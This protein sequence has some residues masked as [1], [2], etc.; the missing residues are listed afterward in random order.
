M[1]PTT[2]GQAMKRIMKAELGVLL[3]LVVVSG[4]SRPPKK[5]RVHVRAVVRLV[6]PARRTITRTKGQPGFVEAYE[7]TSIYP[8]VSGYIEEWL[9]DIGDPIKKDQL[10]ARIFVPELNAEHREKQA[11]VSLDEVRIK[12]AEKM[13][14]VAEHNWKSA[15]AHVEEAKANVKKRQAD[16]DRWQSEVKR[17]TSL[18]SDRIV[19][20]Q[21]LDESK[22][23]LKASTAARSAAQATVTASEADEA[24]RNADFDKAG[25]DI[26]AARASAK[27]TRASEQRLAALVGYTEVHA[28]YSGVVVVRNTN[29]GDY[30]QPANGDQ[31]P[32][33]SLQGQG[34][35]RGNPLYV[36]ARTDLVRVFLD[37]P[38]ME[39]RGVH[40]GSPATVRIQALDDEEFPTQVTRTSWALRART[41][42]LRAEIDLPNPEGKILPHMYAYG[43]V[44]IERPNVWAVPLA[45]VTEIGNQNCVYLY[46]DGRAMQ[47]AV[48][49]GISDGKWIEVA[50]KREKGKWAPLTGKEQVIEADLAEIT[51]GQRVRVGK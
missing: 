16:V 5:E 25:V 33:A 9:V 20:P 43:R 35:W 36:V 18:A 22:K 12:V 48:Q 45:T 17:L 37:V 30:V 24:A 47:I 28:P 46:E 8:K 4:C 38:E 34:A 7:Q 1:I 49:V 40:R 21:V 44:V 51:D 42:T 19:D 26:D 39:A 13:A 10:L 50:K 3:A 2:I 23:Q 11:Q 31:S 41:R 6:E 15:R 29:V 32:S 27:V 14:N